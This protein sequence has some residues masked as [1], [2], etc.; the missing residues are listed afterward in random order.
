M[1]RV[2]GRLAFNFSPLTWQDVASHDTLVKSHSHWKKFETDVGEEWLQRYRL[3]Q[4]EIKN[5]ITNVAKTY[6]KDSRN[7]PIA[8]SGLLI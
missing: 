5:W 2:F 7:M 8:G 1:T 6:Q 4:K 3:H